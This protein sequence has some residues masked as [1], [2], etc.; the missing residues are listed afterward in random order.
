VLE[1]LATNLS[2]HSGTGLPLFLNILKP[3]LA[4]FLLIFLAVLPVV[5][6]RDPNL[7]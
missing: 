4:V 1:K 2:S 7:F 3:P 5:P 6:G